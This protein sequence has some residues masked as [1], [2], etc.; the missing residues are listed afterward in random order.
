MRG[1][2]PGKRLI[3]WSEMMPLDHNSVNTHVL[4]SS[5]TLEC[6]DCLEC[7]GLARLC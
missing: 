2:K 3:A 6:G 4:E 1:L 7:S 5:P